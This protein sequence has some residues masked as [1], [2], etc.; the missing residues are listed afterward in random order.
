MRDTK[1]CYNTPNIKHVFC[2][3][4]FFNK[5]EISYIFSIYSKMVA[6]G[7]WKDYAINV[8]RDFSEF[9]IYKNS[10]EYPTFTI[11]KSF[12]KNNKAFLFS[13]IRR[14]GLILKRGYE[15]KTVLKYFDKKRFKIM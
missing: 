10:S 15:L 4:I 2:Q 5:E 13:V 11:K 7:E 6:L 1:N 9:E 8:L 14:D 12:Q 3:N